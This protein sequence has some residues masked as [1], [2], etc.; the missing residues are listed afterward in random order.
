M[1]DDLP[2]LPRRDPAG[3]K[4]TFGTVCVLGAQAAGPKVMI[5]GPAFTATA[6]LRSGA[7]LAVLAVPRPVMPSALII[8]PGATG[9]ALPVDRERSLLPSEVA[10]LLDAHLPGYDCLAVGPGWGTD[11]PQQQVL[12]R[13]VARDDLPMVIDADGLNALAAVRD[14]HS[15]F[16]APAVLT[17]HPGEFRRLAENLGLEAD[18]VDPDAR[19]AAAEQMARRLGCVVVL[20]GH[21]TVI[22]DG[23]DSAIN[24]SGNVALATAGTGDVL[25]GIIASFI[26]QFF[27]RNLGAGSRQVTAKQQGGLSLFGC[28]RCA[29]HV[30]GVAA[31]LWSQRHNNA[32]LLASDL[33]DLIPEA[34][35]QL[36]R[37]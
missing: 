5:G 32:G 3:H 20:K 34:L 22:S 36:K 14:F 25:T 35:G 33:L 1:I 19:P 9:L 18:P 17:P 28:A 27:K 4:G 12:I 24:E 37:D 29:V 11:L 26:A 13:L 21:R 30:H 31:D 7:G 8:A 6:A 23:I 10:E 16:R 15:D 2:S